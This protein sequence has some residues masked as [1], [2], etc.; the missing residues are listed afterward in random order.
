MSINHIGTNELDGN[1]KTLKINNQVVSLPVTE[2]YPFTGNFGVQGERY[3]QPYSGN[4]T[5]SNGV[6]NQISSYKPIKITGMICRKNNPTPTTNFILFKSDINLSNFV[7][8]QTVSIPAGAQFGLSPVLNIAI[9]SS[10]LLFCRTTS[11][12]SGNPQEV[13]VVVQFEQQ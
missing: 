9:S 1:F 3:L 2:I 4:G 11:S 12:G 10:E 6:P 5:S 8:L 13:Q 7:D